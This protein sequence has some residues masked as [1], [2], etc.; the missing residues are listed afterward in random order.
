MKENIINCIPESFNTNIPH[1][2]LDYKITFVI[3]QFEN[4]NS[5]G[6]FVI[7]NRFETVV[8]N[9]SGIHTKINMNQVLV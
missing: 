5:K 4:S 7:K 1:Q 9:I 3:S 8:L 2:L 6:D